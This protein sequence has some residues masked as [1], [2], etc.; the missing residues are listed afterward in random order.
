MHSLSLIL[1]NYRIITVACPSL[2]VRQLSPMNWSLRLDL[3]NRSFSGDK[4]FPGATYVSPL[5]ARLQT[6]QGA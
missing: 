3:L 1:C 2:I 5:P 4:S 6:Q